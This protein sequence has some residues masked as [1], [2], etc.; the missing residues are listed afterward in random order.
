MCLGEADL[1]ERDRIGDLD[2][3]GD[4]D[5]AERRV[6]AESAE[7]GRVG[8]LVGD[9]SRIGLRDRDGAGDGE[10]DAM[11]VSD[12]KTIDFS[13]AVL[14]WILRISGSIIRLVDVAVVP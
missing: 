2:R 1:G 4:R 3:V 14:F 11:F 5:I 12:G 9:R 10:R 8:D 6:D 7:R 13:L